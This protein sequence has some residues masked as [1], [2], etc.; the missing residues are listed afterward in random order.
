M[1]I[2]NAKNLAALK[3]GLI[4]CMQNVLKKNVIDFGVEYD[5]VRFALKCADMQHRVSSSFKTLRH[6]FL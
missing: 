1:K 2:V 4:F 3:I 5:F 6:G